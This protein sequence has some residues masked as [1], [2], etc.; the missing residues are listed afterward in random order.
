VTGSLQW[1]PTDRSTLTL[2]AL[3][4]KFTNNRDET[5]LEVISFSRSGAGLPQT[6]VVN[7]TADSKGNLIKGTFDDVD[8]RV[9][10]RHDDL[11]T[12]FNQ[13]TLTYDTKFGDAGHLN[14]VYGQS[15]SIQDNPVQTTFSFDRYDSD[16]YSYDYSAND[17]LPNFNYGFDPTNPANFSTAP[18]T[19]WAIPRCC[20]ASRA[21]RSTPSR[22][23][24]PTSTTRSWTASSCATA[25]TTRN[26]ASTRGNSAS[27]RA[28]CGHRHHLHRGSRVRPAGRRHRRR[29]LAPDHR[30]RPR[31]GPAV[32]R[33]DL[34]DR[35]GPGQAE[36]GSV[37]TVTASTP[38][39]TSA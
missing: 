4:A 18:A 38:T 39:A 7:F 14:V 1:R 15:R 5:Y 33:A 13:F 16:N 10:Y 2:D 3:L 28:T 17:K 6:D 37:T 24:A 35:A 9:E 32:R 34:V 29:R 21:R 26:T 12:E 23:S 27:I 36:E 22:P 11:K 30:L 8:A 25:A 19:P 20:A 31:S